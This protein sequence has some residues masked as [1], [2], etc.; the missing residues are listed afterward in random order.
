MYKIKL[1][2][3]IVLLGL[4]G[5]AQ[6]SK[7]TNKFFKQ[8]KNEKVVSDPTISWKQFGPGMAGYNEEFWCHPTDVNTMFM[9]PDMHV[10][11]GSW[12]N[13]KSWQTLKDTDGD[14]RDMERVLD[15]AFSKQNPDFGVAIERAGGVYTSNNRG[16]NW[17]EIYK[18]KREKKG[19]KYTN[20]H[21]KLAINPMDDK[22]W[23]IGAGDFWN[24]K[25]NHRSLKNIHGKYSGRASYGYVLK[26]TNGGKSFSRIA[27]GISEDLDVGRI[28]YHP[29]NPK[30]VFI[31]TNY[32]V[33]KTT[34][35]GKKWKSANKGLPND[36]PR[37]LTSSYNEKT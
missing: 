15:I 34:N 37:D 8:L 1:S 17:K 2:F 9:G 31:A 18:I 29:K 20:A 14:G 28:I 27:T 24:V 36:L 4:Y 16:R 3:V 23:M 12:D 35:G 22:E 33:F 32:G 21:T 5:N 11:Y 19:S 13:G 25:S 6:Q 26:T 30:I 10:S 7:S